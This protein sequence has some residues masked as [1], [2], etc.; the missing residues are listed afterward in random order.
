M[1]IEKLLTI[2][3]VG[4]L[5]DCSEMTVRRWI[6]SGALPVVD[7]APPGTKKPRLRV[8]EGDYR[9]FVESLGQRSGGEAA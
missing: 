6:A 4:E 1:A 7:I 2:T 3:Q 5:W 9:A 8:R